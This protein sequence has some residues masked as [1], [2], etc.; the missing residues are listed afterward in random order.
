MLGLKPA[1][2]AA[3]V[4]ASP[5]RF[6]FCS[7]QFPPVENFLRVGGGGKNLRQQLIR[8]ERDRRHQIVDAD[9][10]W[11]RAWGLSRGSS[12]ALW[13]RGFSRLAAGRDV[14]KKEHNG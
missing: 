9:L 7:S 4:S 8:V 13:W 1:C 2:L 14:H 6:W 5:F 11:R 12:L 10:R 3:L